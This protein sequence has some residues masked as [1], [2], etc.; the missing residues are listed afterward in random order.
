MVIHI[1]RVLHRLLN[2]MNRGLLPPHL[3][4]WNTEFMA[5][6]LRHRM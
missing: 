6:M 1:T 3:G 4:K 2:V 5:V